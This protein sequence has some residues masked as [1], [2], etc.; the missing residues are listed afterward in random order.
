MIFGSANHVDHEQIS[1]LNS[2]LPHSLMLP[3]EKHLTHTCMRLFSW[4]KN[5]VVHMWLNNACMYAGS[6][7]VVD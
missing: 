3:E 4:H 2:S 5:I 6:L 1:V 7:E